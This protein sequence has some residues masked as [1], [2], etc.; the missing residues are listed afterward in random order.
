MILEPDDL[1]GQLEHDD[2][3]D[4]AEAPAARP[5]KPR[6]PPPLRPFMG[7]D[8]EGGGHDRQGR[9]HYRLM[10]A[11]PFELVAG[12]E[13]TGGQRLTTA[14]C[15]EFICSLPAK[16]LLVGFSFG[17]DAT[18]ILRDLPA[19]RLSNAQL[20]PETG[21]V[22]KPGSGLFDD[23]DTGPG[24]S[25]YTYFQDFAIEY[26]PHNYLRVARITRGRVKVGERWLSTCR[27][28]PNSSRT[29]YDAFGFFQMPFLKAL[30]AFDIGRD[31]WPEIEANKA[32]RASFGRMTHA[33]RHYCALEC[34]LLAQLMERFRE[35]CHA[36]GLRPKTWNGA[37]KLSGYLH[38][39]HGTP[40]AEQVAAWVPDPTLAMAA[41][42]YYGGRF[43]TVRIGELG[44]L[45]HEA[46]LSSA[47]PAAM[48]GLPCLEHGRWHRFE[49]GQPGQRNRRPRGL[50]LAE[51]SFRHPKG[52]ILCGLPIRQGSG[53]L[54]WPRQGRGVYWSDEIRS[55]RALG[56]RVRIGAG[57]AYE[58]R[59][60]CVPFD[61]IGPLYEARQALGKDAAGYP[62]KLG[63]A[64]LYGK[65]AQRIGAPKYG[66]LLWAGLITARVRAQMN[67]AAALDP[68]AVAMLATDALFT[69]RKLEGLDYGDGL[70]Q[71]THKTH[72]RLFIAQPG[73]YF[74]AAR[75]K[76]RGVPVSLFAQ[77]IP[78]FEREWGEWATTFRDLVGPPTVRIPLRLFKGLRLAHALGQL[79]SAG[80]WSDERRGF[81]FDWSRKRDGAAIWEG[82]LSVTT[83]PHA[84]DPEL[85]SV[86]H[87]RNLAWSEIDAA[88]LQMDDQPDHVDL[89]P[90]V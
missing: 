15:L 33:I 22:I 52:S 57:W 42:A 69:T 12:A 78:T 63:I 86:P 24:R 10:R 64:A 16:P 21:E 47:Y 32:G 84:G 45:V 58:R 85:E 13:G 50:Y 9:Q 88:R 37:G 53:R 54:Y 66:N 43:E 71:W 61:W 41:D 55:A 80:S 14:E 46:D 68:E 31:H 70:G 7:V 40:T 25:R 4:Q 82:P 6:K 35:T 8:G 5:R 19:E 62:L 3:G 51:C 20:D 72:P 75:P 81:S 34:D 74:G 17:Y 87:P 65:L 27:P 28:V 76:T 11:G 29:I 56:A 36:A 23:K 59:C 48:R 49:A 67:R 60:Q 26:L 79:E 90:V 30:Q 2:D 38:Q 39:L 73:V 83:R 1:A 89:S 77:H 44:Q 18:Q